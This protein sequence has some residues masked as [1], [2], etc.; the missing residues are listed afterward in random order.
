MSATLA[1]HGGSPVRSRPF[2]PQATIDDDERRA[3]LEVLE[4]GVLSQF[5]GEWSEDFMGGPRV[6]ACEEAFAQ[7]LG[8][9][10]AVAVNSAT[11]GLHV[12]LAA[13]GIGP[14][15][16]VIVSPYTMSASAAVIVLQN[17]I[18]VFADIEDETF[19]LDPASVEERVTEHTR[20]LMVTHLFG[21]PARVDGLLEIARRYNLVIVE[22]A[23]QS[24]GATWNG[25]ET[26][27]IGTAGVLSLNYHKIVHSGEGGIVLT[28][29]PQIA[30]RARLSRNHGE[31]VVEETD[32]PDIVNTVGSNFRM[33]E[34]DAAIAITQ[35]GKLDR[36]L[37]GRREIAGYL[38]ARLA[39][40]RNRTGRGQARGDALLLR[41]PDDAGARRAERRRQDRRCSRAG[42]RRSPRL[43]G[44]RQ[45][46]LP[47]GDV[48]AANRTRLARLP[49]DLRPLAGR[50]LVRSRNLP[51]D[52]EA[53][54][55]RPPARGRVPASSDAR[56]CERRCRCIREG[57]DERR[58]DPRR[59]NAVKRPCVLTMARDAGAGAAI[60][61]VVRALIRDGGSGSRPS[62]RAKPQPCSN[63]TACR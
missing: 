41:L 60:A 15:D 7:R 21:H 22:D 44:V 63:A 20:A 30:T 23:A 42:R 28:D 51:G 39:E 49:V 36:L 55:A 18:P 47:A 6:R 40:L 25:R 53:V 2:P 32:L 3:V 46:A 58:R 38:A 34:I 26:G 54:R 61:P 43:G 14:G 29:D 50:R 48:P 24:I 56:G 11:T 1:I 45:A 35:L 37:A 27:A 10:H 52:R 57:D 33:T 9:E 4:S 59:V 13:A 8:A 16:E 19:G 31:V 17:A 62:L 5:L 12:A